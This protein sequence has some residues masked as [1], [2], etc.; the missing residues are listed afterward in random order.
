[1]NAGQV[2]QVFQK[3]RDTDLQILVVAEVTIRSDSWGGKYHASPQR[4]PLQKKKRKEEARN[5][6]VL[7][8]VSMFSHSESSTI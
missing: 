6:L 7:F 8:V 4:I 2:V 1:M 5:A 3:K